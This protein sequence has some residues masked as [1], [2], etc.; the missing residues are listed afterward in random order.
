MVQLQAESH[1]IKLSHK[2]QI[3]MWRHYL[4]NHSTSIGATKLFVTIRITYNL[5]GAARVGGAV[6]L[7]S[8]ATFHY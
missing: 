8:M 1:I 3:E 5:R 7:N 2:Q 4:V 6:I